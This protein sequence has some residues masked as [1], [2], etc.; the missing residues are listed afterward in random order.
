MTGGLAQSQQGFKS[1]HDAAACG[2]AL[3]D[4]LACGSVNRAVNAPFVVAEQAAQHHV[5]ARRQFRGD[6]LLAAAQHKRSNAVAQTLGGSGL[7]IGDGLDI[8]VLKVG[9][10]AKKAAIEKVELAP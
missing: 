10:A 6:F 4:I 1:F 7:V 3:D 9:A 5:G 2:Q 8:T